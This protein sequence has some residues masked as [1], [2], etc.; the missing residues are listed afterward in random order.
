M[1]SYKKNTYVKRAD[2]YLELSQSMLFKRVI[3]TVCFLSLWKSTSKFLSL[4]SI[5]LQHTRFLDSTETRKQS[6]R[7]PHTISLFSRAISLDQAY[8]SS[9]ENSY[10]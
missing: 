5:F 4:V 1:G 8:L 6:T 3:T 10:H 9:Y 7:F 2:H